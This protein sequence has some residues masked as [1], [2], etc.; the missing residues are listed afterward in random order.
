M[1]RVHW[2][3]ST[4]TGGANGRGG[5]CVEVAVFRRRYSEAASTTMR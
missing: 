2:R 5:N 4:R 3:K 1:T